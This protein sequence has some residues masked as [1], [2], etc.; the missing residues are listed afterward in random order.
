MAITTSSSGENDG[1]P[2]LHPY[3]SLN[4][5]PADQRERIRS[6]LQVSEELEIAAFS[7]LLPDGHFG[8][9]FLVVTGDEIVAGEDGQIRSRIKLDTVEA[10]VCREFVGN[11]ELQVRLNDGAV[12]RLVRYSRTLADTFQEVAHHIN[13][14]RQV[15]EEALEAEQ[16]QAVKTGGPTEGKPAYRCLN[17]G[18][19]LTYPSDVCPRCADKRLIIGRLWAFIRGQKRFFLGG[20][21]CS[22]LVTAANLGP[23]YLIRLLVDTSL[24][25]VADPAPS[26]A[27][28]HY[29]LGLVVLAF[30]ALMLGRMVSQHFQIRFMGM[31]GERVV[32]NLRA[33]LYRSLHR[34]SLSYYD[35]EHTGRIMARVTSDTRQVQAFIVQGMQQLLIHGLM[36][37][38]IAGF[39]V[40]E[41]ASLAA[42]ALLPIPIVIYLGKR[43][44]DRFKSVYRTVRRR[45][46]NLAATVSDSV[47]GVRV[48]KSFAQEDREI[49]GFETSNRECYDAHLSAIQARAR[50]R[51]TVVFLMS[52]GTIVVWF[53]GGRQ[54][55]AGTLT[56]GILL[57]FITYMNMF[58]PPVQQLMNLTEVFQRSATAAE[59]I[60]NIMDMP[61]E[62]RDH[63]NAVEPDSIEGRLVLDNVSFGY[64]EGERVLRDINL[65]IEPGQMIG[66]VGETGSG[67]STLASLICRFY[68][69]TSGT[70]SLDGVPLQDIKIHW[71]RS[72]I[73]MVL[74]DTYLFAGTIRDNIAYGK[75]GASNAEIIR[76]AKAAN[77][78]DFIVALAD[79]YDTTVGERGVG[80]SGGEKQRIA[81]ARAILKDPTILILDEATSAVDT[82]TE[83]VIQEAMDRL[84]HGRTTVAIAHR[85]STLRHADKLIVME[86]GR[87]IEAGTH[88]ELMAKDGVYARLQKIQ[89]SHAED[90]MEPA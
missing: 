48:V 13:T 33:Q 82:A 89:A 27:T 29:R 90:I 1:E 4:D 21:I 59:R 30:F 72:S 41:N 76:A 5:I 10:A 31:L 24:D 73:G 54:V 66:L 47:S 43:F 68:D 19:P 53:I 7:D 3:Y 44:S 42:I 61:S 64:D 36:V 85:L 35:R 63:E 57:Q 37:I 51:P 15:S 17:C 18:Y 75:A 12:H 32:R 74:Q 80:L 6:V 78:H 34:L 79:A 65:T 16:D 60:F 11:G 56:L 25:P 20:M 46:A 86:R 83:A 87:I 39:L 45:F 49:A 8:R 88:E 14:R 77:A 22:I 84:V 55:L 40:L 67:K 50:F 58:R 81:I 9:S 62:V 23:G 2:G 69:P 38:G 52:I 26:L 28:R 71:L 70:I